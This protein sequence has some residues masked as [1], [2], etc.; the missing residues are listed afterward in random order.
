MRAAVLQAYHTQ[1]LVTRFFM[2]ETKHT[3]VRPHQTT[4]SIQPAE[5]MLGQHFNTNLHATLKILEDSAPQRHN[6]ENDCSANEHALY[7]KARQTFT[8]IVSNL[9]SYHTINHLL[10]TTVSHIQTND[11]T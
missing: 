11:S 2:S 9:K 6:H 1:L 7:R 4:S 3:L 5:D 10:S 8:H